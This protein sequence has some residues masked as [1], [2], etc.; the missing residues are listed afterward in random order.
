MFVTKK[1][2]NDLLMAYDSEIAAHQRTLNLNDVY[3]RHNAQ[4]KKELEEAKLEIDHLNRDLYH[5]Q[6]QLDKK[7]DLYSSQNTITL[8]VADDLTQVVPTVRVKP[9]VFEKMVELGYLDDTV[10]TENKAF[11]MQTALLVIANEA[12]EQIVEAM[13]QKVED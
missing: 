13:T 6:E 2:H 10:N 7:E 9:D 1:T 3:M 8:T 4:L 12:L 5:C 11:M